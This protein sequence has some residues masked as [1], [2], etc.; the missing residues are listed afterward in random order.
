MTLYLIF[1]FPVVMIGFDAA[2]YTYT[3]TN[4]TISRR[5]SVSVQNGSLDRDVLV[6]IQTLDNTAT[7]EFI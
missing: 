6:T 5:V 7:G 1:H 2:T 4:T 3:E